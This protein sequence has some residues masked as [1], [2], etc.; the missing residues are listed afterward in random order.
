MTHKGIGLSDIRWT[1]QLMDLNPDLIESDAST[2]SHLLPMSLDK[3]TKADKRAEK[4]LQRD[5]EQWL[6]QRGY[7]R[8]S[9]ADI[10]L[11]KPPSG[12]LVH[13]NQTR[14]NPILLDILLLGNDGRYL[15]VELK[16]E[17]G[18]FSSAE[19]RLL[20]EQHGNPVC[21]DFADFVGLVQEWET[22][23]TEE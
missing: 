15:E 19:Q 4:E 22:Q 20:C 23:K 11:E 10:R 12:W 1:R 3:P 2:R 9:P 6:R 14:A 18:R 13:L 16:A 8:R 17:G 5:C 21:W 7:W